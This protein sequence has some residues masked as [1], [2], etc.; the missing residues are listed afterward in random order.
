MRLFIFALTVLSFYTFHSAWGKGKNAANP[1]DFNPQIRQAYRATLSLRFKQARALLATEHAAHPNN[2][3]ADYVDNYID[4]LTVLIDED[5]TEYERLA[6]NRDQRLERIRALGN[7]DSPYYRYLQAQIKIQWAAAKAKFDDYVSGV[8]TALEVKKAYSLLSEN[9]RLYPA[10]IANKQSLGMLHAAIGTIPDEYRWGA[11]LFGMSGSIARG[12]H[13]V[14]EVLAYAKRNDFFFEEETVVMYAFLLLNL[15]NEGESAWNAIRSSRFDPNTN[16]LA[17]F[18]QANVALHTGRTDEAIALLVHAPQGKEFYPFPQLDYTTGF[19]KLYHLDSDAK[20]YL[21][22]YVRTFRGRHYVKDAYMRLAWDA[23][24][25]N[26]LEGYRRNIALC[27]LRGFAMSDSDKMALK[28]AKSGETPNVSLLRARLLFDG[29]YLDRANE[30]LRRI[31][32]ASLTRPQDKLE[33]VYR[34]GRVAHKQGNFARAVE[35]YT[36]TVTQGQASPYYF[37]AN[38]ALQLG[39]LYEAAGSNHNSTKARQYFEL[40]LSLNPAD[41]KESLHQKAKAGLNRLKK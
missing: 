23:L 8:N 31:A 12:Q 24:L 21:E 25:H 29:S 3:A 33:Y 28:N 36:Q 14:E 2:L 16:P 30:E 35:Y 13:E 6:P 15:S 22:R 34:L 9:E 19:A 40:C 17:A 32:P 10:F 5:E 18:V 41:Y 38:A 37:A 11:N 4:I 39:L 27:K 1:Y 7:H 20:V 26:D